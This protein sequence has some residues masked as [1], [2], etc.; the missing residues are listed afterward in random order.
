MKLMD[1][2]K[3]GLFRRVVTLRNLN[4]W[5]STGHMSDAGE[6]VGGKDA[7]TI[8]AVWAC[9][10]LVA[11]TSASLPLDVRRRDSAGVVRTDP[12]HPLSGLLQ[13][14]P[15]FDQ[16][17]MD[18]WEFM[19]A[20]L[21][22]WGNAYAQILRSGSRV[23]SLVPIAPDAVQARRL[24][25][26]SIEYSWTDDNGSSFVKPDTNVFHIRGFGGSPLGGLSTLS[27]ARHAF[28][29][30]RAIDRAAGKT[31][32]NGLRPS[33][34]LSFKEFLSQEN[35]S[36]ARNDL[37]EQ[38]AGAHNA[39]KPMILEGDASWTSLSI[40]PEDA[41]MLE[42]RGFS[43]EDICRFFGVPP[44][45]IGHTEKSTSWGTGL[46]QQTLGFQ[47]YTLRR[48]LRRVEQAVEKQLLTGAERARGIGV[49]FAIEGLLRADSAARAAYYREMTSIGAM[50]I[51]EVRALEGLPPVAGGEVPRMQMQNVPITEAGIGH[52]GGPPMEGA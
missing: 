47:K 10:N 14:S 49:K 33:G 35:R 40:N 23:T 17:A 22:L 20:S 1:R 30:A 32:A 4:E 36:I 12:T 6:L 43:V 51:N 31:F 28:G 52:N 48:R 15:N 37:I 27:Y 9:V 5:W 41:Q 25:S 18:F 16:T 38:F 46:E 26:G 11:G 8:G 13:E 50:T 29:L 24:Q 2:I 34:V 19:F 42:S 7:L 3:S 21:E 39:G 45:M 44:F